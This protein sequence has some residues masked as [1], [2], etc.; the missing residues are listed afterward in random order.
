MREADALADEVADALIA[1]IEARR[2]SLRSVWNDTEADTEALRLVLRD[3]RSF[4][5]QMVGDD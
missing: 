5:K 1:E 2:A 3:Y 4:V